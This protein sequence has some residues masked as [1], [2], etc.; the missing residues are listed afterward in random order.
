MHSSRTIIASD[1]SRPV[2]RPVVY[3]DQFN[4]GGRL[5]QDTLDGLLEE[6]LGMKVLKSIPNDPATCNKSC[7]NGIPIVLSAPRTPIGKALIELTK[8]VQDLCGAK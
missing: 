8:A 3:Y 7:N 6:A 5:G 1:R 2:Y 4:I